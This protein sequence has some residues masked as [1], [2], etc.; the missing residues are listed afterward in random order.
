MTRAKTG[1]DVAQELLTQHLQA[2]A[3]VSSP[4]AGDGGPLDAGI[5]D[6]VLK[7]S[8]E[9]RA[10]ETARLMAVLRMYKDRIPNMKEEEL[11]SALLLAIE[12]DNG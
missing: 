5:L 3:L 2:V 12:G 7:S 1:L 8:S 10:I 4:S 9:L 6:Q 11:K